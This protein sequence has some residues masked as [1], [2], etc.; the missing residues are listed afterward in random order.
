MR[1]MGYR[2]L[3]RTGL[4]VSELCLGTMTFG[5]EG[6]WKAIGEQAQDVVDAIVGR[7]ID[8]GINFIDTANIYSYGQSETQ[9]GKA[10]KNHTRA[11]LL[12][13]TKGRGQ[14]SEE[15][16]SVGLSRHHIMNSV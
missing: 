6:F 4:L 3:G 13:A 15:T 14:M 1:T 2:T 11:N 16:N 12:I 10:L 5:G 8:A 7:S 9:L